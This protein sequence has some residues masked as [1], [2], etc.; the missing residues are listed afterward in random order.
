MRCVA[1]WHRYNSHI[2]PEKK[3]MA[4]SFLISRST[5]EC[6]SFY[7]V[8]VLEYWKIR[9]PIVPHISHSIVLD[10]LEKKIAATAAAAANRTIEIR[11]ID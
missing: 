4:F 10:A 3:S 11:K 5:Q 9:G 2:H 8:N 7:L 1:H 6:S